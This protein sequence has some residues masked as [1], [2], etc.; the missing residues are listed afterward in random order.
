MFDRR[1]RPVRAFYKVEIWGM[2]DRRVCPVRAL[3]KV[4]IWG[5]FDRIVL[6]DIV[7]VASEQNIKQW[8][9]IFRKYGASLKTYKTNL[10]SRERLKYLSV[11][12]SNS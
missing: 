6:V 8:Q 3:Y 9:S 1:V 2:F 12:S 10:K 7:V 11:S 5:V 4:D